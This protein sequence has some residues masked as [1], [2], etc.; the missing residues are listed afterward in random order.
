MCQA[1]AYVS[2]SC[3]QRDLGIVV[4]ETRVTQPD[5]EL[6]RRKQRKHAKTRSISGFGPQTT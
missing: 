3:L 6:D 2:P 1:V 5:E 4:R